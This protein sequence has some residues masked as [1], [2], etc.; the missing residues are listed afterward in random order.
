MTSRFFNWP[1][2]LI[3][4]LL[5]L[6]GPLAASEPENVRVASNHTGATE[7]LLALVDAAKDT[8]KS[9]GDALFLY[10]IQVGARAALEMDA[11]QDPVGCYLIALGTF[12]D[13][14]GAFTNNALT[15]KHCRGLETANQ[16]AERLQFIG[17]PLLAGRHDL[18]LHFALSAGFCEILGPEFAKSIGVFKENMDARKGGSGFSF[19]DLASDFAGVEFALRL[20]DGRLHLSDL[21]TLPSG[22]W[23][24]SLAGLEEGLFPE[25]PTTFQERVQKESV[26]IQTRLSELQYGAPNEG[27]LGDRAERP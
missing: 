17:K 6:G 14:N 27:E 26:L 13:P 23:L 22:N 4:L 18:A 20:K 3:A 19:V 7:I 5:C 16:K 12:F 10:Y 15:A 11:A 9:E 21:A 25:D 24:P 1:A 8:E 2:C